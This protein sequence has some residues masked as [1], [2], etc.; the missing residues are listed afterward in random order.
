MDTAIK[1]I[2]G[3]DLLRSLAIVL[4]LLTHTVSFLDPQNRYY[5]VPVY[6]GYFGVEFFFVLSGFLIGTILLKIQYQEIRINFKSIRIFWIRR[7]FRTL[8]N[9]YLMFL[10]YAMVA[11]FVHHINVFAQL[12]YL[13]YLVFLQNAVTYQPNDFFQVAWSLS[14]EEWFYLLFPV[15][16]F[17]FTRLFRKNR[18]FPFLATIGFMVLVEL[19]IRVYVALTQHHFWDEGFRKMMPLRL[20]S[21]GIGVL[22]AYIRFNKPFFW[23]KHSGKFAIF[24]AVLLL[25]LTIYFSAVYVRY[26]DPVTWDHNFN[27][28]I[29][30]ETLFFTLLSSSVA[31]LIPYLCSLKIKEG[32]VSRSV[33]FISEISYS[34]YLNHLFVIL[35]LSRVFI[36]FANIKYAN[37][38][39]FTGIWV[40]TIA[41][42]A[43][44]Y[45]FF[46]L[47]M[48][49][50]RNNFGRK[51]DA[52]KIS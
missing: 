36:H 13:A 22:A 5:K 14:I 37:V 19:G 49:A 2:F 30:L 9:Y 51:Q 39:M 10:V 23:N 25:A 3:L 47:K 20:D 32:F 41:L 33:T 12:K 24:G 28:G 21:I 4:V 15:L 18:S 29:F 38:V 46:E 52:I 44:Q 8:P 42:S 16:L 26:F 43:I 31:M 1:R 48:T 7:W 11:L 27:P 35:A 6:T 17:L 34:I 40:A 45:K 50:L